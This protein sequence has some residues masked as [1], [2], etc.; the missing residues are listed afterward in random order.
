MRGLELEA[1]RG[2]PTGAA[3]GLDA[4][5]PPPWSPNPIVNAVDPGPV[6]TSS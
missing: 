2:A 3:A 6:G 5:E 4:D 1:G